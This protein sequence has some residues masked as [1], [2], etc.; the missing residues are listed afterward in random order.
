ML[1]IRYF[2]NSLTIYNLELMKRGM[3]AIVI[4][5]ERV[6]SRSKYELHHKEYIHLGG[7]IYNIDNINIMTPKRHIEAHRE[8]KN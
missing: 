6:S 3:S 4:K 8:H 5:S 2:R 1:L 7:E